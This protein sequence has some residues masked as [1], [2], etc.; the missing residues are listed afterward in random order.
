LRNHG[1]G[2]DKGEKGTHITRNHPYLFRLRPNLSKQKRIT[3]LQAKA[4]LPFLL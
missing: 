4:P 1:R 3:F 2:A